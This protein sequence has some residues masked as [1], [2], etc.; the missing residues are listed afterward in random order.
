MKSA[1]VITGLA[2]AANLPPRPLHLAIGM[3]DGVHRGHRAVIEVPVGAARQGDGQAAV[4]TFDPHPSRLLRPAQAVEMIQPLAARLAAL[5]GE[6]LDAIIVQPFV[7]EFA[8]IEAEDFLAYLHRQLPQL[9]SLHVGENWR[10]GRGRRG[11]LASLIAAGRTCG[12][13]VVSA[14]RVN[15]LGEP[16]SSTRIREC[17][18]Q[19]R[20]EVAN[21]M[22]GRSYGG[23]GRV[24]AGKQLGRTL[25]FPTLNLAW[26]VEC[27]PRHGV[28]AVRVRGDAA[29]PAAGLPAVANFGLRPTVEQS[30]I[31]RLEVHVLADTTLTTGDRLEVE[32]LTFLRPEQRFDSIDA[33]RLQIAADTQAAR[34]Y[35]AAEG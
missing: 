1:Q 29:A 14:P 5:A 15:H 32:W 10:Y 7:A 17:L 19:G 26:P 4:L 30:Q 28:Y 23:E 12:V 18:E 25:G 8:A 2:A 35:F 3:F 20:I 13:T 21:A 24:T 11:D 9:V 34:A 22:L 6:G 27:Q 33:L 31:P 16:I